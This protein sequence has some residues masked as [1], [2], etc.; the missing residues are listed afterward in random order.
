MEVNWARSEDCA[1]EKADGLV[2]C[3]A[4]VVRKAKGSGW[5]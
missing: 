2:D 3:K 4:Q 5:S 1:S